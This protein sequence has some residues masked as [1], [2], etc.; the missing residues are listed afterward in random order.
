MQK[1]T[2]KRTERKIREAADRVRRRLSEVAERL[3]GTTQV[4]PARQRS[5]RSVR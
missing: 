4:R 3:G 1:S 2:A 5:G